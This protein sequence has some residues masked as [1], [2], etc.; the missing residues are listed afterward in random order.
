MRPPRLPK[1]LRFLAL[2]MCW[3]FTFGAL[4]VLGLIWSD[5]LGLGTLLS[6]DESGLAT[7]LLFFQSALTFGG[8]AMGVAVMNLAEDEDR[9]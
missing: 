4:F 7:F 6:R 5:F 2:H 1:L 9:P 3:G 8:V